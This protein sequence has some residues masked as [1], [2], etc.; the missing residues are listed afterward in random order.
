MADNKKLNGMSLLRFAIGNP[1]VQTYDELAQRYSK[2]IE[3]RLIFCSE[4]NNGIQPE[5]WII[6]S[7]VMVAVKQF[8]SYDAKLMKELAEKIW[9]NEHIRISGELPFVQFFG[10]LFKQRQAREQTEENQTDENNQIQETLPDE[11]VEEGDSEDEVQVGEIQ[12]DKQEDA[13]EENP[14]YESKK[15]EF[16]QALEGNPEA[17]EFFYGFHPEVQKRLIILCDNADAFLYNIFDVVK[18]RK[19]YRKLKNGKKKQSLL[20]WLRMAE[21]TDFE[22]VAQ[23][24]DISMEEIEGLLLTDPSTRRTV[25]QIF[26]KNKLAQVQTLASTEHFAPS[27]P[28]KKE[29]K[30]ESEVVQTEETPTETPSTEDTEKS[31]FKIEENPISSEDNQEEQSL[32]EEIEQISDSE[33]KTCDD[34]TKE[35]VLEVVF[36]EEETEIEQISVPE[37]SEDDEIESEENIKYLSDISKLSSYGK[38]PEQNTVQVRELKSRSHIY[39]EWRSG[40]KG[41]T[42][43]PTQLFVD[44]N[45]IMKYKIAKL[46]CEYFANLCISTITIHE[47]R[48]L[49]SYGDD[50]QQEYADQAFSMIVDGKVGSRDN[51]IK[52]LKDE[53]PSL[54]SDDFDV[55][56]VDRAKALKLTFTSLDAGAIVYARTIGAAYRYIRVERPETLNF[57]GSD[58]YVMDT[59][60]FDPGMFNKLMKSCKQVVI[61]SEYAKFLNNRKINPKNQTIVREFQTAIATDLTESFIMY[62]NQNPDTE[63][64]RINYEDELCELCRKNGFTFITSNLYT[65]VWFLAHGA[66]A[67]LWYHKK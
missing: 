9:Q 32:Q 8:S 50:E 63:R 46:L 18:D 26:K 35:E 51:V 7:R 37:D 60:V 15:E 4:T 28:K 22:Y 16:L 23:F 41:G 58:I 34:T 17:K 38:L 19:R 25:E 29:E 36:C 27:I 6:L 40:I 54:E 31:E 43:D 2:T 14:E 66:K 5:P 56:L 20:Q 62:E 52:L 47:L 30:K 1:K 61:T 44:T 13:D 21:A 42:D 57:F 33:E 59:G 39:L 10:E 3:Y 53:R 11:Q 64:T 12:S 49:L 45:V 55:Q 24:L 65:Y 67:K 48:R